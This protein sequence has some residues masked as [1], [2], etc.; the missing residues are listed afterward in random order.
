MQD[1]HMPRPSRSKSSYPVLLVDSYASGIS[2]GRVDPADVG[3]ELQLEQ[4]AGRS[5]IPLRSRYVMRSGE[6]LADLERHLSRLSSR[7]ELRRT[8][9]V[10]GVTTDPFHPF[11]D[12]F[13]TSMKFLEL[14]ERFTPGR[15]VIQTRSPLV[16]IGL[17]MLKKLKHSTWIS[18]GIES[19]LEEVRNRYTPDLPT[20]SERWKTVRALKRFGLR[21]GVQVS[22]ILPY[23]DWRSD[24]KI[25]AEELCEHGDFVVVR[26]VIQAAG[27]PRPNSL[28]ARQLAQDRQFFWLRQDSHRPLVDALTAIAPEKLYHPA[29][30]EPVDPQLPLFGTMSL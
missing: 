20:V 18:I 17:P 25:F 22:P 3:L 6:P 24:A 12:K 16:V 2:L 9:I 4:G 19:P 11:D 21:V 15:L 30:I 5:P 23:G 7:G 8:T 28:L 29:G 1:K 27:V 10:F 14:F 13:A 26:S